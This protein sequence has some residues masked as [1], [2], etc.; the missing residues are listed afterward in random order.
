MKC[1]GHNGHVY[2]FFRSVCLSTQTCL[3]LLVM[4]SHDVF[5]PSAGPLVVLY[6]LFL[7]FLSICL[8]AK[9][10][11]DSPHDAGGQLV[12]AIKFPVLNNNAA[13]VACMMSVFVYINFLIVP[14]TDHCT[15]S[16][17]INAH[18]SPRV[19]RNTF[20]RVPLH[21]HD[22]RHSTGRRSAQ[23]EREREREKAGN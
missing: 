14:S 9:L 12:I 21:L 8:P 6:R 15:G 19:Q 4:A 20:P 17:H 5:L 13:C 7:A 2:V 3:R 16:P 23:R 11:P 22:T 10:D 18:T 1:V